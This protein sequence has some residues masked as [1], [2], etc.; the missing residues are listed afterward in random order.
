M[1]GPLI[2]VE[3]LLHAEALIKPKVMS[4]TSNFQNTKC[5]T[6]KVRYFTSKSHEHS[7]NILREPVI[8]IAAK[9]RV[10]RFGIG[11]SYLVGAPVT[12][13]CRQSPPPLHSQPADVQRCSNAV[14]ALE[15]KWRS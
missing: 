3:S 11:E 10:R 12:R 6:V 13:E 2:I 4:I 5:S 15:C 14:V 8:P 1:V 9:V 7:L